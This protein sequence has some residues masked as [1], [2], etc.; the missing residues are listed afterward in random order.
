MALKTDGNT[1]N[2]PWD[3]PT[4]RYGLVLVVGLLLGIVIGVL[5]SEFVLAGTLCESM[6]ECRL[7]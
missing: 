2:T 4:V 7:V 3:E 1:G 5:L 6:R